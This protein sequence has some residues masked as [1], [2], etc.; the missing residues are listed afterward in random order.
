[1]NGGSLLSIMNA[2]ENKFKEIEVQ[3]ITKKIIEKLHPLY[4][5]KILIPN[6]NVQN[7]LI[8]FPELEPNDE[9]IQD[10]ALIDVLKNKRQKLIES[11]LSGIQFEIRMNKHA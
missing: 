4:E 7:V 3:T 9:E 5:K 11:D 1:M 8:H 6:L 10:T 2:R